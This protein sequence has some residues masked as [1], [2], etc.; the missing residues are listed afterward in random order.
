[1]S[2]LE[3]WLNFYISENISFIPILPN[4]KKSA[5][6][7][8]EFQERRPTEE[9][10]SEWKEKYWSKG[11]N[12][13]LVCGSVSNSLVVLDF[14]NP[15]YAE[16]LFNLD[17]LAEN[18]L[19]MKTPRGGYHVYLRTTKPIPSFNIPN[20]VEVRSEGRYVLAPPSRINGKR[21][22]PNPLSP[23]SILV[24]K[25]D[26]VT[27]LPEKVEEKLG[28]KIFVSY[29][30]FDRLKLLKNTLLDKKYVG[31]MPPCIKFI[32]KGV[33]EGMRNEAMIR[34]ASYLLNF[35]K[36]DLNKVLSLVKKVNMFNRPPLEEKEIESLILSTAKHGYIYGC[37]S[38][39]PF[40]CDRYKCPLKPYRFLKGFIL[41]YK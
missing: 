29:D 13:A 2:E 15:E 14:D 23:M 39:R 24:V 17:E 37:R 12:I 22:V 1:M 21:Y 10:I 35:K 28:L 33:P 5:I 9:E 36:M 19:V 7:W 16:K 41:D 34:L 18:T 30:D 27:L 31:K 20:V 26:L 40:G 11:Y 3:R 8:E 38:M 4:S 6:E 25:D 32:T